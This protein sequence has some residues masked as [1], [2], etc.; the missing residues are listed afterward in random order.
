MTIIFLALRPLHVLVAGVWIG[1]T[2]LVSKML[3]PAIEGSGP[4]GGHVMMRLGTAA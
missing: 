1:S 3:T 2:V 4:S